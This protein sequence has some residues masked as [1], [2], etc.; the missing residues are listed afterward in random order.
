[1]L[2]EILRGELRTAVKS[3]TSELK[4][5]KKVSCSCCERLWN[6]SEYVSKYIFCSFINSV[7]LLQDTFSLVILGGF[8]CYFSFFFKTP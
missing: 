4:I 5:R 2:C 6:I 1:M 8:L 7:L 3:A